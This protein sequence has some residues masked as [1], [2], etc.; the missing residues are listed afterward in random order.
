VT[1][2]NVDAAA[3]FSAPIYLVNRGKCDV[4]PCPCATRSI[5]TI[6]TALLPT[7]GVAGGGYGGR[8]RRRY[9]GDGFPDLYVT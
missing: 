4:L 3:F 8:G 6:A 2:V 7:A 9:D 1:V 5:A